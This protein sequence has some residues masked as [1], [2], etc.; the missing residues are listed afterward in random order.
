MRVIYALGALVLMCAGAQMF[1][2]TPKP[3]TVK[4][5]I[6]AYQVDPGGSNAVITLYKC[7][8]LGTI[9]SPWKKTAIFPATRSSV[10]IP[11]LPGIY[12]FYATSTV[13]PFGES[14]PSNTVTNTITAK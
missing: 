7:T 6:D 1:A 3:Q 5:M 2:G 8:W 11:L 14:L 4:L 10:S 12:Y 13:A 9:R